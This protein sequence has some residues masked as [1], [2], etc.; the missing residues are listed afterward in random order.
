MPCAQV[1]TA[2]HYVGGLGSYMAFRFADHSLACEYLMV[3]WM[4]AMVGQWRGNE[5][6]GF[7]SG[8]LRR[9]AGGL[10]RHDVISSDRKANKHQHLAHWWSNCTLSCTRFG[11]VTG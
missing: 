7:Q 11:E 3:F 2:L 10:S 5:D 1:N 9:C 6:R 8:L 4:E